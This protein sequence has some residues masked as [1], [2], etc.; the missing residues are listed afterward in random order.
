M[1]KS[2]EEVLAHYGVM[3]MKWGKRTSNDH[4]AELSARK[5]ISSKEAKKLAKADENWGN[6][7]VT[8]RYF[9]IYNAAAG[10]INEKIP[11]F[12]NKPEYKGQDF[13]NDTP[14]RRKYYKD[15]SDTMVKELN[16][17]SE[18]LG[19]VNPSGTKKMAFEYDLER[20][21]MPRFK[22]VNVDEVKQSDV[23]PTSVVIENITDF[24]GRFIGIKFVKSDLTHSGQEGDTMA[25]DNDSL[26]HYGVVGMK[27]GKR[28]G[29]L[30]KRW[31][32]AASDR[33]QRDMAITK[34]GIEGKQTREEKIISAPFK[35]LYGGNKNYK[36][37]METQMAGLQERQKRIDSNTKNLSDKIYS[38]QTTTL[39]DLAVSRKDKKG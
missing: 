28:K 20:D 12:N 7:G 1:S 2:V 9:K 34:R 25:G 17:F 16:K 31:Q 33:N 19:G 24:K 38:L 13:T 3:G 26:A 35:V 22:L 8:A 23:D 30:G 29:G 27:C 14:L 11:E 39:F 32:G 6:R 10:S 15:Y 36:K 5:G 21:A 18:Q 4:A 37:I